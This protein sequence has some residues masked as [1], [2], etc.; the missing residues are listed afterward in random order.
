MSHQETSFALVNLAV[1]ALRR[2]APELLRRYKVPVYPCTP[3]LAMALGLE[4]TAAYVV[5]PD[6]TEEQRA[7][8]HRWIDKTLTHLDPDI[9]VERRLIEA[10][11]VAGGIAK[12]SRDFDVVVIG[13]ANEPMFR[14]M[15]FGEIPER[16]AGSR[17]LRCS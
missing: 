5:P 2:K 14:Q 12:E 9:E 13:A 3:V 1:I 4:L 7:Q 17:P 15:L 8:A 10:R 16:V 6:A 11:S